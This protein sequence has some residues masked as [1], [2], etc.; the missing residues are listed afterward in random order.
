MTLKMSAADVESNLSSALFG[1]KDKAAAVKA[2]HE[3]ARKAI[4]EDRTLS[5]IGVRDRVQALN[6]QTRAKL[7]SIRADQESYI[8]GLRAKVESDLR[9]NQPT[10]A[11]SVLL[12]RDAADR[13]RKIRDKDEALE[14]LNDAIA[15]GDSIMAHAI[16][17]RA[18]N[19]GMVDVTDAYTAAFPTTA[20][21]AAAL[22]HVEELTTGPAFNLSNQISYAPPSDY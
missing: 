20:D 19:T 4:I 10:D 18:Q 11:N 21:S 8:T 3:S 2:T 14:V 15:N 16:G 22:A 6:E 7:E 17:N 9:G 5:E 12:R 13:A 1:F